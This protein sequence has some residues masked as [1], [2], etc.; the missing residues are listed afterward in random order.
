MTHPVVERIAALP[1]EKRAL[2]ARR[3][4]LSFAQQRLW[5]LDQLEPGNPLYNIPLAVRLEGPLRVAAMRAAV[6]EIVRR[7]QVLRTLFPAF[8][9][10]PLQVALPA[11]AGFPVPVVDLAGL[12]STLRRRE[13]ARLTRAEARRAFDLAADLPLR[14]TLLVEEPGVHRLLLTMHHIVSDGGS[15]EVFV[16]ELGVLLAAAGPAGKGAPGLAPLPVL[17]P[18]PVQYADFAR[19]QR[20]VLSGARLEGLLGYWRRQLAGLAADL[21]LPTDCPRPA[22]PTFRGTTVALELGGADAAA[23]AALARR[24]G[25]TSFMLLLAG[26]QAL[27]ARLSGRTDVAV[28][29]PA[30]NRDRVELEGLI[31]LFQN[32]VVLR[33]DC[34]GDPSF[35]EL[36][37]RV[38]DVTLAA[39]EHQELPFER[40]VDELQPERSLNRQPLFQVVFTLKTGRRAVERLAGLRVAPLPTPKGAAKFDLTLTAIERPGSLRLELELARDLFLPA[41]AA[42]LLVQYRTLLR[43]AAADP[44]R[45]LS[46]LPLSDPAERHQLLWEWN[47]SGPALDGGV[48]MHRPFEEQVRRRPDATALAAGGEALSYGEL[49]RRA[50]RL[51]RWL[52]RRGVGPEV[53]VGVC[54]ERSAEMV[55]AVLAV[56]K[57]GGAYVPLDPAFP[58]ERSSLVLAD[59]GA[60]LVLTAGGL[61][62]EP[63]VADRAGRGAGP[64][65]GPGRGPG[66]EIVRL[67]A[68]RRQVAAESAEPP[69]AAIDPDSLAYLIY[70]SGSTGRPKGVEVPHRG[71]VSFLRCMAREL[72]AGPGDVL[73]A[74][75]TLAFDIAVL[76]LF[77]P[78]AV[79]A[80]VELA[81]RDTASDGEA[82]LCRLAACG[83]TLL[84]AT[85]ATWQ[86]LLDAGWAGTRGLCA[87]CGGEALPPALAA[88]LRG[89]T[90]A[91]WNVYGP[92]ETTIW[93]TLHRVGGEDGPVPL[94]RPLAATRVHLLDARGEAVPAG[95]PGELAIGGVGVVRGYHGQPR[96]TAERFVPDPFGRRRGERLYRTGDLA[97]HRPDGTLA[98]LGRVDHQV[99]VRGFRVEPGE[100]EARLGAHPAVREAAVVVRRDARDYSVLVGFLA[101]RDG[102]RGDVAA[103]RAFLRETLPEYMVPSAL[104]AL[105]A[106]PRTP[107]GKLDR[108]ALP[109]LD[110]TH[111]PG[112]SGAVPVRT[113]TEEVVAGV[114]AEVL[115]RPG[116]LADDHFFDLGGHSLLATQA[117]S[118]L[119][120]LFAVELPLR[121]L[122]EAPTVAAMAAYIDAARRAGEG[123]RL[124]P[125]ERVPRDGDLPVSFAQRRLWF[126]DQL[127]PG[128][129]FYNLTA[130]VRLVGPL[131]P[132]A[133]AAALGELVRRHEALRTVFPAAGG[134]PMQR[135]LSAAGPPPL[136]VIDLAAL[137]P[138][139]REAEQAAQVRRLG[140]RPFDLARGPLLRVTLLRTAGS[141]TR[142]EHAV[143]V[144]LH[145]VIGDRWSLAVFVR[146]LAVLY[147]AFAA[148]KPSPLPDL[149]VQY[150]DFAAWQRRWLDD[151]TLERQLAYWRRHLAGCPERLRLPT[152]HPRPAVQR[153]RGVRHRFRLDPG[154]RDDLRRLGRAEGATLFMVLLAGFAALL[155]RLSGQDDL[156]IG[157]NVANRHHLETEGLIGFFANLLALRTSL[158]GDP[159]FR[160]LLAEVREVALGAYAHQDVPFERLVEELRPRRDLGFT[161]LVQV[162]FSFQNVPTTPAGEGEDGREGLA[163]EPLRTDGGTAKFDLVLDLAETADGLAGTVEVDRDLFTP[164]TAARLAA[165]Y[166]DLLAAAAEDPGAR[167]SEL[168]A[169]LQ[170]RQ[171][172]KRRTEARRFENQD[173]LLL[174][175]LRQRVLAPADGP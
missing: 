5:F 85:P 77:L 167:L 21:E 136:P 132:V 60:A 173:A 162:V 145:H 144:C 75:T 89:R 109:E 105:P 8:D 73:L 49:D 117:V 121:A 125:M 97:R 135:V 55:V 67:D 124:P 61:L 160:A 152:D 171:A 147:R 131:D 50:N 94:G 118:R 115:G 43:A 48:A 114:W 140:R 84:Q 166:A 116:A 39:H 120:R 86:L 28:G 133:L 16:R 45:P 29:T 142:S 165:S 88:E 47:D 66:P 137:D 98:F 1:R 25:V 154:L 34:G 159:P 76:E 149:P 151:E 2:L 59:A 31:G 35:T 40:L 146:E 10:E 11:A 113:P 24:H 63:A 56:L 126:L 138:A 141:E 81:D 33:T 155:H 72:A 90:A 112:A 58:A 36:L 161:P 174:R 150:G 19:W 129:A 100:I 13:A 111:L 79:G 110:T 26:F 175:G 91:L 46:R 6:A 87:L 4:P 51:A 104:V 156:V 103:L 57:A 108:R 95:V 54:L 163:M 101:W 22:R 99:K 7:H 23:L 18:L 130:A 52:V 139:R 148:G 9:G 20:Q 102:A 3:N 38:R 78:L 80:R 15:F 53:R 123:L 92:T 127:E 30:V 170:A 157:A 41:T 69:A 83:A 44:G 143:V 96:A 128:S 64:G 164:A 74:V 169:A 27:I 68:I 37:A 65:G 62:A 172:E 17:P 14:L 106:L 32:T 71:V 134:E 122:F 168:G 153:H 119:R 42:R 12:G 107:N 93:S 82:L 158:A 70:T